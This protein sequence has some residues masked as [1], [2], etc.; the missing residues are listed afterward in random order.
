MINRITRMSSTEIIARLSIFLIALLI[1]SVWESI[2]PRRQLKAN[3]PHR[4]ARNFSLGMLERIVTKVL[5]PFTT[6]SIAIV[7]A[8][9]NIGIFHHTQIPSLI[10]FVIS[11]LIL[12]FV[13]YLQH[14]IFHFIPVFWRFHRVHHIDQD[15][16]VTTGFRVHPLQAIVT[17][18]I[19]AVTVLGLGIPFSAIVAFEISVTA[20]LMF[21]HGNISYPT[22]YEKWLLTFIITPEMHR[23][24][25]SSTPNETNSNYG[26]IFPWWDK[27]LGTYRAQPA[28][29]ATHMTIGLNQYQD[30]NK[31]T[32]KAMLINPFKKK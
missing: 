2:A 9:E 12:D 30:A 26:F 29:G 5:L 1:M 8:Q 32:L 10:I 15:M 14:V 25:H 31:T 20:I 27:L 19:L 16:D 28:A 11:F 23:V 22:K 21:N 13:M 6:A 4:W 3:K 18:I 7:S 24:H 17:F